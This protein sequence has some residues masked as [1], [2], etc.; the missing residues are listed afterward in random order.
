M[1]KIVILTLAIYL[2]TF[3]VNAAETRHPKDFPPPPP[4]MTEAERAK[5]E[6]A[7]EQRLGLTDEQ[8]QQAKE[9]RMQ[10]F[11]KIKPVIDELKAK[12]QEIQT[13]KNSNLAPL[14][15]KE[16]LN[17]LYSDIHKLRKEAHDIRVENMKGFEDILTADQRKILKEMKQ[18]G[19]KEYNKN[20][21]TPPPEKRY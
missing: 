15:Q 5:K 19:K 17:S 8:K 1:K 10:G 21:F 16:K 14:A 12:E 7:F 9:L 6:A 13:V 18:E 2:S 11:E 20:R 3:A 4:K